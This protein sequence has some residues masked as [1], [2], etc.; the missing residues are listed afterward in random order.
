MRK[1]ILLFLVFLSLSGFS[2]TDT[3]KWPRAFPITDYKVKLNDSI[4]V[5]QI[6][7]PEGISIKDKQ[8][9]VIQGTYNTTKD[10]AVQKGYGRCHLIKGNYYYF[11]I[12]NNT[13]GLE[14]KKGDLLYTFMDKTAIYYGRIPQLAAHFIELLTVY[15]NSLYDPYT[16]FNQWE[17]SAE[18]SLVDS[19]VADIQFTGN[20]F[21]QQDPASDIMIMQG[22]YKGKSTFRMMIESNPEMVGKFL[23]YVLARP[24]LYAGRKWKIS[25]IFATWLSEGAPVVK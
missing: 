16:L 6:E 11:T 23:D 19:L 8:L 22:D 12:G 7:L 5:V 24:R 10:E 4:T 20:Y 17:R 14:L 1:M 25:E 3:S 9:G 2:Q 18:L 15:E 13:S 21:M